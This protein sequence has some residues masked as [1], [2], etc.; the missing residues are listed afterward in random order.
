MCDVL[1]P[2]K[3][4]EHDSPKCRMETVTLPPSGEWRRWTTTPETVQHAYAEVRL[5]LNW[6][7][8]K[9]RM[10]TFIPGL[11]LHVV[12]VTQTM[13]HGI[14]LQNRNLNLF[15][16]PRI[17]SGDHSL[18][19]S[20]NGKV[21]RL[22]SG[23]PAK[24][25]QHVRLISPMSSWFSGGTSSSSGYQEAAT[26]PQTQISRTAAQFPGGQNS[27]G[28]F[29][30]QKLKAFVQCW[31]TG[32]SCRVKKRLQPWCCPAFAS[33][34]WSTHP[35]S[36]QENKMNA[37]SGSWTYSTM[38]SHSSSKLQRSW[39][40]TILP[41]PKQSPATKRIVSSLFSCLKISCPFSFRFWSSLRRN[42]CQLILTMRRP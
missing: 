1:P 25:K 24:W 5:P 38:L 9:K 14:A 13:N 19:D 11:C 20:P 39:L 6:S 27:T 37:P 35:H 7:V 3:N 42:L 22:L 15:L 26:H 41:F 12:D 34:K 21:Q 2:S 36:N 8:V 28:S 32:P 4:G 31:Q 30:G 18:P 33:V 40:V 23:F 29:T 16:H 10:G 17:A